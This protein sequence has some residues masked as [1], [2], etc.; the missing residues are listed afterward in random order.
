[1]RVY[2]DLNTLP[3]FSGAIVTLGSFDGVHRGHQVILE[4]VTRLAKQHNLPGVVITFDPHPREVLRPDQPAPGRITTTPEKAAL[5]ESLGLDILVVVPFDAQFAAM[6]AREYVEDFLI[7]RFKPRVV[8]VGYDHRF[9]HNRNG[10][11]DFLKKYTTTGRFVVEEIPAHE[12]DAIA[13]SSTNIRKSLSAGDVEAANRQLGH[14]FLLAG[15]VIAGDKIGRSIGFPTANLA[16]D[17][18]RKLLLPEGIYAAR[19]TVNHSAYAA[20]LYIGQRP[21]V[22]KA[23]RRVIEVH[24]LDFEDDIYDETLT[25]SVIAFIRPDKTLDGLSALQAQIFKDKTDI[26]K[27]LEK[28]E[29]Q[30]AIAVVV[31]NYHT[32][33]HLST[34]L[35]SVI[36]NSGHA[37]IIVADNGSPQSPADLL[38]QDFPTV[39]FIQLDENYGF[40]EGYNRAL[41]QI[42]ADYYMILNSDVEVTP[43]WLEPLLEAMQQ[44]PKIGVLQPKI[45]AYP[46]KERF[47]YAGAA[48][49]WMD[50]LGYPFCR[51]RIFQHCERDEGQY[52]KAEDCFWAAGAAFFIRAHLYHAFGGFDGSYFAHNEE[53]DLCWRLKRAGYAVRCIPSSVV[54]HL[55]GGTLH[56]ESPRKV[57][58]NF[59][60]SLFTLLKN[61][62]AGA[63]LWQLPARLLLDGIAGIRFLLKGEGR[64]VRSIIRAHG[65]FY[66]RFF[67]TLQSRKAM[68]RIIKK[69]Q[70]GPPNRAGIFRG[71]IVFAHYVRGIQT[72]NALRKNTNANSH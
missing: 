28:A 65:A 37:T 41:Q 25:V 3:D 54:Y 27:A 24:L 17:D 58:L 52:D 72:F 69:E 34:F 50:S 15:K 4:R 22:S 16:V 39:Q 32:P 68:N 13:V 23:G 42:K 67:S 31:L 29:N 1:M 26:L 8:V 30:A 55:G 46:E 7:A 20:M 60:N 56:Y 43:G 48:G 57:F 70:I 59:R 62:H 12:I 38:A 53:I 21:T 33:G 51:G 5:L 19:A 11:M 14:P 40:A 9:G 71:S 36:A 35:P 18:P 47:E 61:S 49:G 64:A 44:D 63:L 6:S 10:D 66:R 45:G 2:S